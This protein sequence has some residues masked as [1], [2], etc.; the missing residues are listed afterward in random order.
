MSGPGGN[1]ILFASNGSPVQQNPLFVN[2]QGPDNYN[3]DGS[4]IPNQ[5]FPIFTA[6][7]TGALYNDSSAGNI[8][9][10]ASYVNNTGSRAT[11]AILG[12]G[13]GNHVWGA[14]LVGY[15]QATGDIA[16][17]LE[18]D[19]GNTGGASQTSGTASGLVITEETGNSAGS[20]ANGASAI[21]IQGAAGGGFAHG[22]RF[23]PNAVVAAGQDIFINNTVAQ[24]LTIGASCSIAG[25]FFDLS[26]ATT[27]AAVFKTNTNLQSTGAG[28]AALGANC[29]AVTVTA[30]N[31]WIK[32][33]TSAGSTGFI[34]VWV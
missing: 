2:S 26:G 12:F 10:F 32:V 4:Q 22:I 6:M 5:A 28:S 23:Q 30:P 20:P 13:K 33:L 29:P 16:I 9:H 31:T 7:G 11:V 21:Q 15:T 17:A 24:V 25:A 1:G 8:F 19:A 18:L 34:P 27:G 14:N 3:P